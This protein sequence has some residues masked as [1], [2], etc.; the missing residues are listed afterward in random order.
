GLLSLLSKFSGEQHNY[1]ISLPDLTRRYRL[2]ETPRY[3]LG[4]KIQDPEDFRALRL[5]PAASWIELQLSTTYMEPIISVAAR[6]FSDPDELTLIPPE[7]GQL[8]IFVLGSEITFDVLPVWLQTKLGRKY[9]GQQLIA[10]MKEVLTSEIKEWV[11][12]KPWSEADSH[13]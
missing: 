5:A 4:L 6:R 1:H 7:A 11:R 8:Q 10:R 9:A 12:T 3:V 2:M 13:R